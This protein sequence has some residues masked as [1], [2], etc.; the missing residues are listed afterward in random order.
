MEITQLSELGLMMPIVLFLVTFV[1]EFV[2]LS[3]KTGIVKRV[4]CFFFLLPFPFPFFPFGT[5]PSPCPP[6]HAQLLCGLTGSTR[7]MESLRSELVTM[8]RELTSI[9]VQVPFFLSFS[10]LSFFP[11]LFL[12]FSHLLFSFKSRTSLLGGPRPSDPSTR[13]VRS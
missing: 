4:L 13:K 12:L 8:K 3:T 7:E 1:L 9:S 6:S 10:L 5:N 11:L 2:A